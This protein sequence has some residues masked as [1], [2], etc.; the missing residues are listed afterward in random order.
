MHANAR[1]AKTLAELAKA[2]ANGTPSA[3]NSEAL[4]KLGVPEDEQT[5]AAVVAAAVFHQA[6]TGN[7]PAV[8]KWQQLTEDSA[9]DSGRYYLPA[10]QIG[11]AFVDINRQ[12]E[13]NKE[14][15]FK[16]GRGSL[17]SSFIG[18]KIVEI[19][20]NYPDINGCVV[21]KVSNTIKDSVYAQIKWCILQ[22][23]LEEEFDFKVSPLEI[24]YKKTGQKIYF[25]GAD[26][27]AK[28][29][30]IKPERGYIGFLWL[31]EADQF[32]GE[33]EQRNIQQ[34][35]L[36]GAGDVFFLFKSFNPPKSKTNFMNRYVA[37]RKANMVVH[38]SNY[39]D[40]PAEWLGEFFLAEAA[41]LAEANPSA[42]ENEYMGMAN[43]AGGLVFENVIDEEITDEQIATFDRIYQGVDWG[44]YPDP[45]V[46]VRLYYDKARETIYIFDEHRVNKQLNSAT[47]AWILDKGYN[48]YLVVCDSQELKSINDYMGLGIK[49]QA[50]VK[51]PGSVEYG[52]KWLNGR[53]IVIDSH[54][55]PYAYKE[56]TEYEYE[57]DKDGN[58]IT[59]Y[60]DAN[61]HA[62]DATRYALERCM[63]RRENRA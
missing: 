13:P 57:K 63:A 59:G 24:T 32:S 15:I 16:G 41:H 18:F 48:D 51:G 8:E 44:W 54:R 6:A 30:S 46:F 43:G 21:R 22:L 27:P 25:R 39:L 38:T 10:V 47:A 62:I 53:K 50:A 31:E 49:A 23:G 26:D 60:P 20:K 1:R 58:D 4:A 19:I 61:N 17:K 11:K 55:C 34:S 52:I 2:I 28:L 45:Y 7:I 42:Y 5:N 29:K 36:R 9:H 3:K 14:Y 56:F 35:V 37:Q 12:I 40:S 33:E